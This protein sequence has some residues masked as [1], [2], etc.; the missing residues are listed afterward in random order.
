MQAAFQTHTEDAVS[1]TIN[2]PKEAEVSDVQAA[3]ELAWKTGCKGITVYRDGCRPFQ[4]LSLGSAPKE[5][6]R[7]EP[8]EPVVVASGWSACRLHDGVVTYPVA[9]E[10]PACVLRKSERRRIPKSGR[11][12]GETFTKRTAY[13]SVH[14]T[15][16]HHPDDDQPFELFAALGKGGSEVSA[17]AEA[18]G[19]TISLM[20]STSAEP[21]ERLADLLD[22]LSDIGGGDSSGM[23][24]A[25]ISSAADGIAHCLRDYLGGTGGLDTE[26][27]GGEP[28]SV[29]VCPDCNQATLAKSGGCDVCSSCGYSKC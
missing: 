12:R 19:R 26:R 15:I 20:L 14:V 9:M 3:Y 24:A 6:S 27:K 23:G 22:Q 5:N 2:L 8:A 29:D 10:C 1:K 13:G 28:K 25:R 4:T 7:A 11:R 18:L 21:R 16:N 17:W